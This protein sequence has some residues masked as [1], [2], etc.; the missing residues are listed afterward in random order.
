MKKIT[1]LI[2]V[3]IAPLMLLTMDVLLFQ[4]GKWQYFMENG[5]TTFFVIMGML[6]F[7]TVGAAISFA[8]LMEK[9]RL[10]PDEINF[11]RDST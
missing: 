8:V 3:V 5:G 6:H 7:C 4:A 1:K 10:L 11:K 9:T 2:Y